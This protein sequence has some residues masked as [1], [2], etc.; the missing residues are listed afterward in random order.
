M[1]EMELKAHVQEP[2]KVR[3]RVAGFATYVRDFDKSDSYWHGPQWRF[4][5]GTKGFRLR[6]DGQRCIVTFKVKRNEGGIEINQETEFDVSDPQGFTALVERIGC[7]PFYRKH[8][9]G[10]AYT[11]DGF[12]IELVRVEGL[13]DFIEIE[14]LLDSDDPELVAVILG[15]LKSILARAG[16]RESDIEGRGYSELLLG[17]SQA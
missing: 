17:P 2:E 6:S 9:I 3:E 11:Y 1:F 4:A 8:K 7:E 5:R 12:T 13:G 14:K 16:V 10:S 15:G